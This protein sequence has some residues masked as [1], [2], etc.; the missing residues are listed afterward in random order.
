MN[1]LLQLMLIVPSSVITI[2]EKMN[3]YVYSAFKQ[4]TF[5]QMCP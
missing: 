3:A 5:H 2:H 4:N 1:V